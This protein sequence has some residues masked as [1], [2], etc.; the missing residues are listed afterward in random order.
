MLKQSGPKILNHLQ[1]RWFFYSL[2]DYPVELV[3]RL[4]NKSLQNKKITIDFFETS[5]HPSFMEPRN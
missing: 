4:N 1:K 5:K 2:Y 3:W